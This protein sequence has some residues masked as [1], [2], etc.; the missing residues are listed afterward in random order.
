MTAQEII[1][2]AST[3]YVDEA[4]DPIFGLNAI[5]D[6]I[7]NELPAEAWP[8]TS[9]NIDAVYDSW[10]NLPIDFVQVLEIR[11]GTLVYDGSY[12]IRSGKIRFPVTA[13]FTLYYQQVPTRLATI[14]LEP[15]VHQIYHPL[16]ALW[17]A[18]KWFQRDDEED[19]RGVAYEA[20]FRRKVAEA[21]AC[22]NWPKQDRPYTVR[23]VH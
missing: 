5:N 3:N 10:V 18:A 8:E 16:L 1:E 14:S 15:P 19:P 9:T 23:E 7:W 2:L 4:I 21:S 22:L 13:T 17:V 20:L 6:A 11:Q 12:D